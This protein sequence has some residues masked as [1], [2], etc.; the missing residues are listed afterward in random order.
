MAVSIIIPAHNESAVIARCLQTMLQDAREDELE[1]IVVANGCSDDTA[2][3]ARAVSPAVRVIDTATPGK[4]NAINVGDEAATGFPRFYVDAD[5]QLPI[6][7]IRRVS[8]ISAQSRTMTPPRH[9]AQSST[10]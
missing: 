10:R 3:K 5:V 1:I 7:S 9:H 6:H 2:A 8:Q 4:S